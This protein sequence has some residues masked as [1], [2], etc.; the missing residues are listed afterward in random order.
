[1]VFCLSYHWSPFLK[2]SCSLTQNPLIL[3]IIK[4]DNFERFSSKLNKGSLPK[5]LAFL[6]VPIQFWKCLIFLTNTIIK[7]LCSK[8]GWSSQQVG[9]PEGWSECCG[10]DFYSSI[11]CLTILPERSSVSSPE[12]LSE[13]MIE[14]VKDDK[15]WPWRSYSNWWSRRC[16]WIFGWCVAS[17]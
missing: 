1:M 5:T 3:L 13:C 4:C 9:I 15:G 17:L 10:R 6:K 14:I 7:H 12:F 8:D 11:L 2:K 16:W